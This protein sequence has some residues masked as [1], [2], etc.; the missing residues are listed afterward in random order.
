MPFRRLIVVSN[1]KTNKN[2][3]I[4]VFKPLIRGGVVKHRSRLSTNGDIILHNI[5][6]VWRYTITNIKYGVH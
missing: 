2:V 1:N 4:I 6:Y 3:T 5:T